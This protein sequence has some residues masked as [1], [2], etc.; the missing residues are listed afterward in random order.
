MYKHRGGVE[1]AVRVRDYVVSGGRDCY[2]RGSDGWA[3]RMKANLR[4]MVT[5]GEGIL[6]SSS[7][8]VYE[9]DLERKT[10]LGEGCDT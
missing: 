5:C 1:C 2:I 8:K 3:R 10:Q 9:F 6:V 7:S 4:Q